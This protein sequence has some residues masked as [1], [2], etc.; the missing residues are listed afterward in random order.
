[1][2]PPALFRRREIWWPTARGWL[3]LVVLGIGFLI[4]VFHDIHG[5]LATTEPVG[6]RVLVVEG[7]MGPGEFDEAVALFRARMGQALRPAHG[8][9]R[10]GGEGRHLRHPVV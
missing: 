2:R 5:F 3:V 4:F 6:A 8:G 1:V 10:S 7:W 9:V